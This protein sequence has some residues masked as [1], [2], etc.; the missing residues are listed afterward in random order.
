M[1]SR[2]EVSLFTRRIKLLLT[3]ETP[4][5]YNTLELILRCFTANVPFEQL[6]CA[7]G[8]AISGDVREAYDKIVNKGRGGFCF[9]N[10][11]VLFEMLKGLGFQCKR[12]VGRVVVS[13]PQGVTHLLVTVNLDGK[14]YL[15]DGGFGGAS[16]R[17]PLDIS[18]IGVPIFA[19]PDIIRLVDDECLFVGKGGLR[20]QHFDANKWQ[21]AG[22]PKDTEAFW[23]NQWASNLSDP[24]YDVDVYQKCYAVSTRIAP[25]NWFTKSRLVV[26]LTPTGIKYMQKNKLH[27]KDRQR[28][29]DILFFFPDVKE[30]YDN[31]LLG[32]QGE[33]EGGP[34][35]KKTTTDIHDNDYLKV[36]ADNFDI[37]D[38]IHHQ[39]NKPITFQSFPERCL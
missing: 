34:I 32:Q 15:V 16:L 20:F 11:S 30:F 37:K 13:E 8:K 17:K 31:H 39:T 29:D 14:T 25:D 36:L 10:N 21:D 18:K 28:V 22:M 33:D 26:L 35:F 19:Y 2:R 3:D 23:A 1:F 6:D 24:V 27:T 12:H 9:E 4:M 38:I 5:D 7:L